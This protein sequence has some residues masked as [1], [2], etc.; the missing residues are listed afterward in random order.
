M[1]QLKNKEVFLT[2]EV[3]VQSA[4]TNVFITIPAEVRSVLKPKKGDKITYTIY[5]DRTVEIEVKE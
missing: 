5:N 2:K 1:R 4:G 3:I